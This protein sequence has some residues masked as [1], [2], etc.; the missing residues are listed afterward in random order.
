MGNDFYTKR[1]ICCLPINLAMNVYPGHN[2][3]AG[4]SVAE[5]MLVMCADDIHCSENFIYFETRT[6]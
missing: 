6:L 3:L 5:N 4:I 2:S 1:A